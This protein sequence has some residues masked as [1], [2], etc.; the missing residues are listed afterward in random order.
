MKKLRWIPVVLYAGLIFYL[1]SR[2][3]PTQSDLPPGT[4]KVIHFAI[5]FFLGFGLVWAF[6]A[7]RFKFSHYLIWVAALIGFS[8]GISDEIH[9]SFVPGRDA[10]IFDALADGIGSVFGAWTAIVCARWLRKEYPA[11][12][13]SAE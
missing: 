9:Q 8:Y 13:R 3:W 12:S 6:R 2:P 7:T 1:S 10:S 4:D 11:K 5:Y